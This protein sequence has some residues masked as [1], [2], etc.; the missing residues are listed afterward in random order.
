MTHVEGNAMADADWAALFRKGVVLVSVEYESHS[1]EW[2]DWRMLDHLNAV[3][4]R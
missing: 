2:A 4:L 1:D 3:E